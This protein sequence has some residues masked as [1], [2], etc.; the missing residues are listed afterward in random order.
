MGTERGHPGSL[1]LRESALLTESPCPYSL[2]AV[3]AAAVLGLCATDL[4]RPP[5]CLLLLFQRPLLGCGIW[6]LVFRSRGFARSRVP[7][8]SSGGYGAGGGCDDGGRLERLLLAG[9]ACLQGLLRHALGG[10]PRG[11]CPIS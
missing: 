3:S 7:A 9:P 11:L 6:F 2:V 5:Q 8:D 10:E 1:D 4:P